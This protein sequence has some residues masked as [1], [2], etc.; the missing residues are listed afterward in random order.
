MNIYLRGQMYFAYLDPV[1]GSE[2]SGNRPVL[3]LQNN[4]GNRYGSTVI[5][6]PITSRAGVEARLPTH[7]YMPD[8]L[9]LPSII[10]L[11]QIRTL[12]KQRLLR[13]IGRLNSQIM[14]E[15]DSKLPISLGIKLREG[16]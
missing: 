3:L 11:E 12:D 5:A 10:L 13:Y 8:V 9:E 4:T 15:V 1:V 2:Q 16:E 14:H 6:A 7:V